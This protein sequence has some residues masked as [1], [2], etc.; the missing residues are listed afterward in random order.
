VDNVLADDQRCHLT[1]RVITGA[2]LRRAMPED[3]S[4]LI[5]LDIGK[6]NDISTIWISQ[7]D[8]IRFYQNKNLL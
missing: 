4:K 7:R 1:L 2:V 3:L 6:K 8:F 5:Q